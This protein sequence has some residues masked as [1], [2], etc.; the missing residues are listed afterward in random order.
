MTKQ[1]R[2]R[3]VGGMCAI[4]TNNSC[5]TSNI[6]KP[7]VLHAISS[8][9]L[10]AFVSNIRVAYDPLLPFLLFNA[11]PSFLIILLH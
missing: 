6:L 7:D 3:C 2:L 11:A 5:R 9:D 8:L 4:K 10:I 1:V